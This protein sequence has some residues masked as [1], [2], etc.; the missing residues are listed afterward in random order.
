MHF[1]L[2]EPFSPYPRERSNTP[3]S[4][5][6]H[7]GRISS[8][9]K[10]EWRA[11]S[12]PPPLVMWFLGWSVG[13]TSRRWSVCLSVCPAPSSVLSHFFFSAKSQRRFRDSLLTHISLARVGIHKKE[14]AQI[15][16]EYGEN[17]RLFAPPRLLHH[18]RKRDPTPLGRTLNEEELHM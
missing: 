13:R 10:R 6:S 15:Q 7:R 14:I 12:P 11:F 2:L 17:A 1:V 8:G 18:Q 4:T 3:R 9:K 16:S 5:R